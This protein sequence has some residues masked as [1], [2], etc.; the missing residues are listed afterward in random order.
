MELNGQEYYAFISYKSED[1]TWAKWLQRELEH[2]RLPRNN[3]EEHPS[4]SRGIRPVFRDSSDLSSGLLAK[5]IHKAL[6]QS[7][8]LIVI[9]SPLAAKS[10]WV[11]DE[12][13]HF[14]DLGQEERII[15]F[16][17]SGTPFSSASEEEC[18]PLPLRRLKGKREIRGINISEMGRDA[19]MV[20]VV[21]RM[22]DCR[23]DKLWQRHER[24][25]R[26]NIFLWFT[27]AAILLLT[28]LGIAAYIA[29]KNVLLD[30]ANRELA[31]A[32]ERIISEMNHANQ[33]R[34]R[35]NME[36]DRA[37][38]E[39][40]H[41]DSI[42]RVLR[43]ANDSIL[44]QQARILRTDHNLRTS[45]WLVAH[46]YKNMLVNQSRRLAGVSAGLL[47]SRDYINARKVA[48]FSLPKDFDAPER[49][50]L[51]EAEAAL[52]MSW[53]ADDWSSERRNTSS[54]KSLGYCTDGTVIYSLSD[55]NTIKF[56]DP[57][58]GDVINSIPLDYTINTISFSPGL[59]KMVMAT[60]SYYENR[61]VAVFDMIS[62]KFLIQSRDSSYCAIFNPSG[63]RIASGSPLR[64]W[65]VNSGETVKTFDISPRNLS[66]SP[67]GQLLAVQND[68]NTVFVLDVN[69]GNVLF[70]YEGAS[71]FAFSISPD[72]QTI[73]C[74]SDTLHLF[75][76]RT[77]NKRLSISNEYRSV[78]FSPDGKHF[79]SGT[80]DGTIIIY[81]T[82]SWKEQKV[83]DLKSGSWISN[84][85]FSP[86]GTK[87]ISSSGSKIQLSD[88]VPYKDFLGIELQSTIGVS[89]IC[90][91][92]DGTLAAQACASRDSTRSFGLKGSI[93]VWDLITGDIVSELSP[94][95]IC[96]NV[97]IDPTGKF[98]YSND[99]FDNISI[100]SI[101]SGEVL[102]SIH[103][104]DNY[105]LDNVRWSPDGKRFLGF[106]LN[107]L[108]LFGFDPSVGITHYYNLETPHSWGIM[109]DAAFSPDRSIIVVA[110]TGNRICFFDTDSGE[111][112]LEPFHLSEDTEDHGISIKQIV[113]SPDGC[114]L[115]AEFSDNSVRVFDILTFIE[116]SRFYN[117]HSVFYDC[118]IIFSPDSKLIAMSS[119]KSFGIWDVKSGILLNKLDGFSY[120]VFIPNREALVAMEYI[121]GSYNN[122]VIDYPSLKD[123]ADRTRA[124]IDHSGVD[125]TI[126]SSYDLE[127]PGFSPS[128]IDEWCA[129]NWSF[130]QN[131]IQQIKD[132]EDFVPKVMIEDNPCLAYLIL[133]SN[134]SMI[135]KQEWITLFFSE[136]EDQYYSLF[137]KLLKELE[138]TVL[139]RENLN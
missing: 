102:C 51:P 38:R 131:A 54:I 90:V 97:F 86:D 134:A 27:A 42:S 50:I 4:Q 9:C 138:G 7:K 21:A 60:G 108:Q 32:N 112:L 69:S 12:I 45:N 46:E 120:P 1:A 8:Y 48:L 139:R 14:I 44:R 96:R 76:I 95:S 127:E 29:R 17:I 119:G 6:E 107:Q 114:L 122:F 41:A 11:A 68:K 87:L 85:C 83:L 61:A 125:N 84:L 15:P 33:E 66:F 59:K 22:L 99:E 91:S 28:T 101:K 130:C 34:D 10:P 55:N 52:R 124:L 129:Q 98:L 2:Y 31:L 30:A 63:D 106:S 117:Y 92:R 103:D 100:W 57:H 104:R 49:T 72:S 118:P 35:A 23:F 5:E 40:N 137:N 135:E 18:L 81:D 70:R 71:I 65:D 128:D 36:K 111:E 94:E 110:F 116:V 73:A 80:F 58:D 13:Q 109:E 93:W 62:H 19:A 79:A 53:N 132:A 25:K 89:P 105:C 20:K 26:K 43:V 113:Y 75:D 67:D 56:W 47:E 121:D 78:S 133:Q 16:I 88:L 74:A 37:N 126:L 123:L 82:K 115:A 3:R 24:E 77:G 136:D 39:R 64:I